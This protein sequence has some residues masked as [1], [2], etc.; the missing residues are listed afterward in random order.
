MA[1]KPRVII[2]DFEIAIWNAIS[3]TFAS[4]QIWGCYFHLQQALLRWLKKEKL[5]KFWKIIHQSFE[6]LAKKCE[7][8]EDFEK[9]LD[10]LKKK[11]TGATKLLQYLVL[12]I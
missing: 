8:Q 2:C 4:V 9:E 5:M 3:N 1:W 11:L 7:T 6:T 10:V 12:F